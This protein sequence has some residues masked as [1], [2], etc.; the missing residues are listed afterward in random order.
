MNDV[1]PQGDSTPR[2]QASAGC[3]DHVCCLPDGHEGWHE[4]RLFAEHDGSLWASW[5]DRIGD[6]DPYA[7][8]HEEMEHQPPLSAPAGVRHEVVRCTRCGRRYFQI[9]DEENATTTLSIFEGDRW[10]NRRIRYEEVTF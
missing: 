2:C 6:P 7:C 8:A 5:D 3:G 4:S 10:V 9:E 1:G